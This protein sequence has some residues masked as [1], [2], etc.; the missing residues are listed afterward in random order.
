MGL[1]LKAFDKGWHNGLIF[2]FKQNVV[3]DKN[4]NILEDFLNTRKQSRVVLNGQHLQ[5]INVKA[6]VPQGLIIV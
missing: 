6:S 2:K 3:K 5:L 1:R 4:H